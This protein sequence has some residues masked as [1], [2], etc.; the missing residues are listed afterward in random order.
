[1]ELHRADGPARRLSV[2]SETVLFGSFDGRL[3]FLD[4]TQDEEGNTLIGQ[5]APYGAI[6]SVD[7][8]TGAVST[9]KL[10]EEYAG[11]VTLADG[12]LWFATPSGRVTAVSARTGRPRWQTPTSLEQ[13][14]EATY[15]PRTRAVYLASASG[16][17]GALD[18]KKGT[19]LWETLPRAQSNDTDWGATRVRLVAGALVAATPGGTVFSLDPA[20]PERKPH[21]G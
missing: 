8:G 12:T 6:R 10:A 7:P 21:S 2:P 17:V 5:D 9:T 16:R 1:M 20:H 13:P 14:S 4:P 11:E 15:D 19:L 18:A 3:L